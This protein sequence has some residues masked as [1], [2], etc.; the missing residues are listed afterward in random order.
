MKKNS[1][2]HVTAIKRVF[3]S[4]WKALWWYNLTNN[5]SYELTHVDTMGFDIPVNIKIIAQKLVDYCVL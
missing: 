3:H 5:Y 2:Y 1:V 4:I